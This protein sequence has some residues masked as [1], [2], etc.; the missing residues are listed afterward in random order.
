M[1]AHVAHVKDITSVMVPSALLAV[2]LG[3]LAVQLA[4]S[5]PTPP[6]SVDVAAPETVKLP[7]GT[8]TFR[9]EGH[10]LRENTPIDGPEETVR[11]DA[12]I[13]MMQYQ[14]SVEDYARCVG[15]GACQQPLF[16]G[17]EGEPVTGVNFQDAT[18][19]A[20]WLSAATGATWTLPTDAEWAYAAAER[21]T[22]DG[23]GIED[24][25]G[26]P[27]LRWIADYRAEA[28]RSREADPEPHVLG[29]FGANTNGL[30]DMAGNVWEWTDTCHRRVHLNALGEV[31]SE[32]PACTVRVLEGKHRASTSFF[33]RDPKSGGCSVGIPPD[34]LGF[35]LVRRADQPTDWLGWLRV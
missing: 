27:A 14:V 8:L 5:L 25:P 4:P 18:D 26:N 9:P 31:V 23:L 10:Y 33:I 16:I 19:Y 6:H 29:Y 20:T 34:N 15:D 13:D 7:P 30:M 28:A 11:F 3:V 21:F 1:T 12:G 24:D 35:R 32:Q 17:R 22:D 2:A